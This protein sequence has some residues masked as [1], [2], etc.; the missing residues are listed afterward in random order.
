MED[1]LK[2]LLLQL[3]FSDD[4]PETEKI[5]G[6]DKDEKQSATPSFPAMSVDMGEYFILLADKLLME[7]PLE[8]LS[9]LHD[10]GISSVSRDFSLQ[11]LY[12][13][14]RKEDPELDNK[15]EGKNAKEPK[16]KADQKKGTKILTSK[17]ASV[18]SRTLLVNCIQVEGHHFKYIVDPNHDA[19]ELD[20]VS[21]TYKINQI[22][23][24]YHQQTTTS[25]EGV[26][27][28]IHVPSYAEWEKLMNNCSAFL[29]YGME[30][31]LAHILI[32]KLV[33]MNFPGKKQ[34]SERKASNSPS[35]KGKSKKK[36]EKAV[37]AYMGEKCQLM[38]LLDLVQTIPSYLTQSKLDTEKR[39]KHLALETPVE[40]AILLSLTGVRSIM[41]N[42]WHTT[43][44]KNAKRFDFLCESLLAAGKTTGQTIRDLQKCESPP[45]PAVEEDLI[46]FD[47]A[48]I[49]ALK[50]PSMLSKNQPLSFNFVLYGLPNLIVI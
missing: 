25:W 6:K 33:A 34:T 41:A 37:T 15:K 21:P 26:I 3:E 2:P 48:K 40:T 19:R 43:L 20:A 4:L 18:T 50:Y 17:Q 49:E 47:D 9:F 8:A 10:E 45:L 16:T 44:E 36:E 7:L 1:Y 35:P 31:F 38:I 24:K 12:N 32:D 22:L 13:R 14:I 39:K 30:R 28:S 11:L 23:E 27:G 46:C 5:K 42:Q 29:F